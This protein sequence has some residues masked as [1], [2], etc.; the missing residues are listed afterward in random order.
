MGDLLGIDENWSDNDD[1]DDVDD[2]VADDPSASETF[3][4]FDRYGLR[5]WLADKAHY[6]KAFDA[7]QQMLKRAAGQGQGEEKHA[8]PQMLHQ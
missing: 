7:F 1:A 8:V 4:S 5:M 2:G 6:Q 3:C